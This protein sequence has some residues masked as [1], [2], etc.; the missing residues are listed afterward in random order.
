MNKTLKVDLHLHT[1]ESDGVLEPL[2]LLQSVASVGMDFFSITD[3]DTLAAYERHSPL[4]EK[5]GRRIITGVEVSTNA[6]DREVHILGYGMPAHNSG[7]DGILAGR[8]EA[9]RCRA[10]RM[11]EKL[12]H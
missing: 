6:G 5:F 3:H 2:V 11:V 12:K 4:F 9:R 10:E 1:T 8:A 7:L